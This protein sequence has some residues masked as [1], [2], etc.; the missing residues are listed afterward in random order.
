MNTVHRKW[1]PLQEENLSAIRKAFADLFPSAAHGDLAPRISAYW[2]E[3]LRAVWSSKPEAIRRKD[4]QFDPA[5]PM[6]RIEQRTVVIAYADS[7]RQEGEPSLKTLDRF[8]ETYFPAVGGLHLL[9]ACEMVEDRFN[10]GGFSQIR[11]DRIHRRFGDNRLFAE[12]MGKYYAMADFVLN[13]VDIAHPAFQSYLE[14]DDRMADCF[15][16]FSEEAY[17]S[18]L[19]R[20]DFDRIFRPRPFPLF[21][22][23]RRRPGDEAAAGMDLAQRMAQMGNRFPGGEIPDPVIG[24]M[25]VLNKVK[26]DQM[27]LDADYRYLIRFR[28]YLSKVPGIDPDRIFTVSATQEI[29]GVPYILRDHIV[30]HGD[31]LRAIGLRPDVAEVCAAIYHEYDP[32]LFGEEIRALTTFSHVQVDLNTSTLAGLKLLADDFSW[33]L[34]LD[35]NLLR[36][37]AANF[38]FKKWQTTCFGLPEVQRLVKIL[39]LSMAAVSPRIVA[40]LEVNDRL[41]QVLEQMADTDS[42]PP[43]MYDFH[44]ASLIPATFIHQDPEIPARIA[45]LVSRYD[46]PE[47]SIRFSLAES[48]DGKSVR[49]GLDLLSL[50]ELQRLADIVEHNGGRIKYKGV[51]KREIASPEFTRIID[52]SGLD[53]DRAREKLFAGASEAGS[54]L[55]LRAHIR[56]ESDLARALGLSPEA[57]SAN[58]PLRFLSNRILHGREPYELCVSTWDA[59]P[60]IEETDLEVDRFLAFYALAFSLMGR[61]LKSVYFN[62]LLGL[63]NDDPRYEESGELRDLKRTKSDYAKVAERLGDPNTIA[64]RIAK[65]MNELIGI[66]DADPSLDPRGNE[67]RVLPVFDGEGRPP[68]AAVFNA[69]SAQTLTVVNLDHRP[70]AVHIGID[71]DDPVPSG[72]PAKGW[73]DN[74]GGRWIRMGPPARI[75][76]TLEPYQRLWLTSR[77]LSIPGLP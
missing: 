43:M 47:E 25:Y 77:P 30:T 40:N 46:T 53:A 49:G 69:H 67:A 8:L 58:P 18:R 36:L 28:E 2:T 31:L 1:Q 7:V 63:P 59:L 45:N 6:S 62:D 14:G 56:N 57:F 72:P 17:Q 61:N 23:F 15:Y 13:H 29:R 33:Y 5:D 76:L 16:V 42:P 44:L 21:T 26:N 11:R 71:L 37:D 66:V 73:F 50:G 70:V 41:S 3:M 48:H 9:P 52:E 68:V 32:R 54:G 27:L 75:S 22:I 12:L 19:S 74:I 60:A 65:G 10:D 64:N 51:P 38:A 4:L 24:A 55:S 39:Y 20:G 35:L 34:S